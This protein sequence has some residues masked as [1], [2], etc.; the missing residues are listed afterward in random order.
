MLGV[1]LETTHR[2]D[3]NYQVRS[4][5]LFSLIVFIIRADAAVIHRYNVDQ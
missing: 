3:M 1:R 4:I 5:Y 2:D